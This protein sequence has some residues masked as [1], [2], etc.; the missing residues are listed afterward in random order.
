MEFHLKEFRTYWSGSISAVAAAAAASS[1][2]GISA[3]RLGKTGLYLPPGRFVKRCSLLVAVCCPSSG[4][5]ALSKAV[6]VVS[7]GGLAMSSLVWGSR[8]EQLEKTGPLK[9]AAAMAYSSPWRHQ[10]SDCG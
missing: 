8:V 6:L 3:C 5:A 9:V 4:F 2:T 7:S 10:W 1:W